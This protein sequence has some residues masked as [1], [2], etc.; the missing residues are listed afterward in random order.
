MTTIR[1]T[2]DGGAGDGGLG[3]QTWPDWTAN[4]T[5]IKEKPGETTGTDL[6]SRAGDLMTNQTN[7]QF[8]NAPMS[9]STQ[10]ETC[11]IPESFLI[12]QQL[13]QRD[14]NDIRHFNKQ[15]IKSLVKFVPS[16]YQ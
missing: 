1:H 16:D 7:L 11:P 8:P 3:I 6:G 9:P 14:L 13:R 10:D 15:Q 4:M 5:G 12:T 2:C